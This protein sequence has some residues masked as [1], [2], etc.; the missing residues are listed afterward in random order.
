VDDAVSRILKTLKANESIRKT[1]FDNTFL[2]NVGEVLGRYGFGAAKAFLL[3]KLDRQHEAQSRVLL[4]V[5][6]P[7]MEKEP[8][9]CQNRGIV[10]YIVKS[11][12]TLKSQEV[13]L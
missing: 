13:Q 1:R 7:I 9:L 2:A 6:I 8:Q 10:R 3:D 4:D 11:L 12:N 5:I